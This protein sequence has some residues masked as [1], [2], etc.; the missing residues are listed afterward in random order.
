MIDSPVIY[1]TDGQ[2]SI[3]SEIS[4]RGAVVIPND[5]IFVIFYL[6]I[7]FFYRAKKTKVPEQ[8]LPKQ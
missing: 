6:K 3:Y 2:N 1:V 4:D 8:N 5:D 7:T